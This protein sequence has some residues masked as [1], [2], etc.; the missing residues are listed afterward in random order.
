[1]L[2]TSLRGAVAGAVAAGGD[3]ARAAPRQ[4]S[5][6]LQVRRHRDPGQARDARRLLATHRLGAPRAERRDLRRRVRAA[7]AVL[8]R[9]GGP[10]RLLVGL[11]EHVATWLTVALI[12][13]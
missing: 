10:P 8:A 6:R 1:M 3:D 12:D 2:Q 7:Q 13:R 4:T 5:L 11:I 9:N